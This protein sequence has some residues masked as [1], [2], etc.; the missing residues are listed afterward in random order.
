MLLVMVMVVVVVV[1]VS[2]GM[3]TWLEWSWR[4][5]CRLGTGQGTS[6]VA[7]LWTVLG[8]ALGGLPLTS[9]PSVEVL[10]Q[11]NGCL[12]IADAGCGDGDD[13]GSVNSSGVGNAVDILGS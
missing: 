13:G 2:G 4:R 1:V 9:S 5:R 3:E 7:R 6:G 8:S 11:A 10:M 12:Q